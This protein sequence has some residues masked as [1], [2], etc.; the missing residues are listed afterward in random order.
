MK[1][2]FETLHNEKNSAII[3]GH[4]HRRQDEMDTILSESSYDYTVLTPLELEDLT[5]IRAFFR[6]LSQPHL[7]APDVSAAERADSKSIEEAREAVGLPTGYSV[8]SGYK[9]VSEEV[10]IDLALRIM[11]SDSMGGLAPYNALL[12]ANSDNQTAAA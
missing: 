3:F 11:G 6:F 9:A 7:S 12:T 5:L 1:L 8:K 4:I 10:A 2:L